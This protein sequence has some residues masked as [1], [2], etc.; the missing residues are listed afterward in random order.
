GR[1]PFLTRTTPRQRGG[2][3][4]HPR[5]SQDANS[6]LGRALRHQPR[7]LPSAASQFESALND[8]RDR[9]AADVRRAPRDALAATEDQ[10]APLERRRRRL[11][12]DGS[13]ERRTKASAQFLFP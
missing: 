1:A 8:E 7:R 6:P 3:R 12:I 5:K 10:E 4:P 13:H 9:D 2:S 11:Q